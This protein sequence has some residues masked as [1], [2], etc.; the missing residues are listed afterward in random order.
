MKRSLPDD[1]F[2]TLYNA[3]NDPW[4]LSSSD[5][6]RQKYQAT[7]QALPKRRFANGFEVGCAIGVLT[8][9][10]AERVDNLLAVDIEEIA[11]QQA[12]TACTGLDNVQLQ[13][14]QIPATW[15]DRP[16]DLILIS[17]VLYYFSPQA[18]AETA[19]K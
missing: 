11:L 2:Q 8:R 10:L 17:E 12:R 19:R 15:P 13:R 9:M 16:F 3:S 5:Y 14:M 1:Y 18:I 6:E 7:L 4:Q